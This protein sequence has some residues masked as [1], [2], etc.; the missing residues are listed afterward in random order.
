MNEYIVVIRF[1]AM[2][3][4][5]MIV[6]VLKALVRQ[7]IGIKI[8]FVTKKSFAS[9][10]PKIEGCEVLGI[11]LKIEYKGFFG[12][13]KLAKKINRMVSCTHLIDLHSVLRSRVLSALIKKKMFARIDKG[14]SE[15]NAFCARNAKKR[16]VLK[17][18]TDRYCDAFRKVGLKCQI[19]QGPWMQYPEKEQILQD[20]LASKALS[21]L[22][23]KWIGIAP[24]AMHKGKTWHL[25]K[26]KKVIEML[27]G[28]SISRVFLFGAP[29]E[30][31]SLKSL[32]KGFERVH[33]LAGELPLSAEL[34]F[35][36]KLKCMLAMDS[37]NMHFAALAGVRT[38]SVWGAT[39]PDVGFAPLGDN[40]DL[41]VQVDVADLPCRPCSV[42][43]DK[44]CFRNDYACME[45]IV[46]EE[47]Y[48]KI[49]KAAGILLI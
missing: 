46:P 44:P 3:D 33:V 9:I 31:E 47:V 26:V 25:D 1:S 18:T 6:P 17:H 38:V 15:K 48:K 39:H 45:R 20:Y 29:N 10:I 19:E 13:L 4:I 21:P 8:L 5:A 16:V 28:H 32:A 42:F 41:I 40:Q 30:V 27:L 12:L 23:E 24:F 37:S 35:M 43:G 36:S 49:C 7:N 34:H 14:R 22:M 2:G 11:D